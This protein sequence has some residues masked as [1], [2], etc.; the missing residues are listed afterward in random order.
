MAME[1][2]LQKLSAHVEHWWLQSTHNC[3]SQNTQLIPKRL[4]WRQL[5][6]LTAWSVWTLVFLFFSAS[7]C[8]MRFDPF[9]INSRVLS[10]RIYRV[11][12]ASI[13]CKHKKIITQALCT[14]KYQAQK[15]HWEAK[16]PLEKRSYNVHNN[17][18]AREAYI[19]N[20]KNKKH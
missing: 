7:S 16:I 6:H 5:R 19:A 9:C 17:V 3:L 2:K 8:C 15:Y 14:M 10:V 20:V 13:W 1:H 4:D 18:L 12:N 11:K